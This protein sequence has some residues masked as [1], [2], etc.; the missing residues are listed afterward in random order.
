M[1]SCI[2]NIFYIITRKTEPIPAHGLFP[3]KNAA[4]Y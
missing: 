3:V 1:S 4:G 2:F